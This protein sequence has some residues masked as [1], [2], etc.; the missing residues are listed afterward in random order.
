[1][2]PETISDRADWNNALLALANIRLGMWMPNP[3]YIP[4][5]M[6]LPAKP[7]YPRR[8]LG[9]LVKEMLQV[10]DPDDLYVYIT[11]GGHWENLGVIELIRRQCAEI[12]ASI[13]HRLGYR[14]GVRRE[15]QS[16]VVDAHPQ[17]SGRDTIGHSQRE[18]LL[19]AEVHNGEGPV[20][21]RSHFSAETEGRIAIECGKET[22]ADALGILDIWDIAGLRHVAI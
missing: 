8:R 5:D 3:R 18:S 6:P 13:A 14:H 15:G 20:D 10:Y 22:V 7:G 19:E 1:M 2:A 11:D 12:V 21:R 9:Y 17:R 16:L 4:A